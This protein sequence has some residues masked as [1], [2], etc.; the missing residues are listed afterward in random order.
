MTDQKVVE[1]YT[2]L[3]LV[4]ESVDIFTYNFFDILES[5]EDEDMP[6]GGWGEKGKVTEKPKPEPKAEPKKEVS[7]SSELDTETI[8][9]EDPFLHH[10]A[11]RHPK[12]INYGLQTYNKM[13]KE[14]IKKLKAS[15]DTLEKTY[16]RQHRTGKPEWRPAIRKNPFLAGGYYVPTKTPTK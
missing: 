7:K 11:T 6:I 4:S 8:K 5:E 1:P 2:G 12:T 15:E 13:N 3:R 14:A 10:M 9:K 16:H